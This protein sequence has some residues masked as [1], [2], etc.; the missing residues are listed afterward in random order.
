MRVNHY[1]LTGPEAISTEQIAE[2]ISQAVDRKIQFVGVLEAAATDGMTKGRNAGMARDDAD[3]TECDWESW[4]S[5]W[6]KNRC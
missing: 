5:G 2:L 1:E 3:R 6:Y 4:L